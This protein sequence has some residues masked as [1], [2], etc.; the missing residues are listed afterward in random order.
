MGVVKFA[1]NQSLY[2][3]ALVGKLDPKG[4]FAIE[5]QSKGQIAP[6]PYDPV[7]FPGKVCK[8]H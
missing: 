5:W 1:A 8:L 7:A 3:P 2:Q 4:Q 6:D